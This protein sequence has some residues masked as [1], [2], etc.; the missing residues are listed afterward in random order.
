LGKVIILK[1]E[2]F[3]LINQ[4]KEQKVF[5]A[6]GG[7]ALNEMVTLFELLKSMNGL[8]NVIFDLSLARGLDYY[9]GLIQETVLLTGGLG[10]ISG[11]YSFILMLGAVMMN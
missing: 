4:L 11:G 8:K 1:G 2:P 10:S 6:L 5:D 7:D 3:Q 9:T